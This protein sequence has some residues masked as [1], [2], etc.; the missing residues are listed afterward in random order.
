MK[1][2]EKL[3]SKIQDYVLKL[4]KYADRFWYPPLIGILAILDNMII[5]IPN[6]GI[7]IASSMLIPKRWVIFAIC[8]SI[9]STIGALILALLVEHKGFPW[10]LEFFPGINDS[11]V[12]KWT[13]NFFAE[14][15]L[16]VVFVVGLSPIFQQPVIV[17]AALANTPYYKLTMAIF[18]GRF[19]KYLFMAYVGSHSPRILK[20][21]WGIEAELKD[22]NVKIE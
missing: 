11:T 17:M 4:E 22:A 13:E 14:Y 15:G 3:H 7:L 19:I 5:V 6:D 18:F 2:N 1:S 20:K 16:I 21:I 8:V 9:G 12:W 10:V